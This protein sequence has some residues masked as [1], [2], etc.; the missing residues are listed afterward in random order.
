MQGHG[1]ADGPQ[2][3]HVLP[4]RHPQQRLVL[5]HA[6]GQ[7]QTASNHHLTQE[8]IRPAHLVVLVQTDLFRALHISMVTRTDK[9]M[10]MGY[11]DSNTLQS[12][13]W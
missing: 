8:Q 11:G 12:R 9:A 6:E 7:G 2:Q 13:P 4:G 5:R 1:Q 3:P 10:V